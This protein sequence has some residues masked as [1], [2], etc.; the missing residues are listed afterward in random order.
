MKDLMLLEDEALERMRKL[1]QRFEDSGPGR[2]EFKMRHFV[3][4]QHDT[5]PQQWRQ[6]VIEVQGQYFE[7]QRIRMDVELKILDLEQMESRFKGDDSYQDRRQAIL[8]EK[9]KLSIASSD[10]SRKHR[11]RECNILYG[12]LME[13]EESNGGVFTQEQLEADEETYWIKRLSRQMYTNMQSGG[14]P[15]SGNLE[16]VAQMLTDAGETRGT[17]LSLE[18]I[19]EMVLELLPEKKL[20]E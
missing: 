13:L 14:G 11:L 5:V 19:G 9:K 18:Q 20:L 3:I 8:M 17:A 7:M 12:I 16:A 15:G 6:V 2:S 4:A 10:L 1:W